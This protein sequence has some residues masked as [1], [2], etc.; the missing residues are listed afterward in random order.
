MVQGWRGSY[1]PATTLNLLCGHSSPGSCSKDR[2]NRRGGEGHAE[3]RRSRRS[4]FFSASSATPRE[5]ILAPGSPPSS[6][7]LRPF[8]SSF[9]LHPSKDAPVPASGPD[10]HDPPSSGHG[11][12]SGH[13][14]DFEGADRVAEIGRLRG[15]VAAGQPRGRP[16]VSAEAFHALRHGWRRAVPAEDR[17]AGGADDEG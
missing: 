13:R 16:D 3:T 14:R 2:N 6:F 7:A 5:P 12:R 1:V 8:R 10:D 4:E 9:I 17:R 15:R 11:W